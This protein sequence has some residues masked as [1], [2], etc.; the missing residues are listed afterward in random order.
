MC[1]VL[2]FVTMCVR[3]CVWRD[4]SFY[5]ML[6]NEIN[7]KILIIQKCTRT[8][9][10]MNIIYNFSC[11]FQKKKWK[12]THVSMNKIRVLF[13]QLSTH[14][15]KETTTTTKQRI[16]KQWEQNLG[17]VFVHHRARHNMEKRVIF[18]ST[19]V[20]TMWI[21]LHAWEYSTSSHK[22]F[23]T[24]FFFEYFL[25]F[26]ITKNYA[27]FCVCVCKIAAIFLIVCVCVCVM[28]HFFLLIFALWFLSWHFGVYV[29]VCVFQNVFHYKKKSGFPIKNYFLLFMIIFVYMTL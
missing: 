22:Y 12:K 14:R 18:V 20:H 16:A 27:S 5:F 23:T 7:T 10:I 24:L 21:F 3:V 29:C 28:Y 2:I 25:F 26:M 17:M 13:S 11:C 6:S 15:P 8:L 19:S 4:S 1:N 9:W